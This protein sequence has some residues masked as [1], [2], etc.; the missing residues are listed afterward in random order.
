MKVSYGIDPSIIKEN[1][2][3]RKYIKNGITYSILNYD[4]LLIGDDVDTMNYRS[5]VVYN[6]NGNCNDYVLSFSPPKS[7]RLNVFLEK[8]KD[9]NILINEIVEGS[10]INLWYDENNYCWE[11]STKT[12]IGGNNFVVDTKLSFRDMF[13]DAMETDRNCSLDDIKF[14]KNFN[15]DYNYSFVL[16]HPKNHFVLTAVKPQLYLIAVYESKCINQISSISQEIYEK[17]FLL[18]DKMIKF[19][20]IY[21]KH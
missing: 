20:Q 15:K 18:Q 7:I 10:M 5:V 12:V 17:W 14:L 16:Q 13:M 11:I 21:K 19:P 6:G 8:Y 3:R 1:I 2:I 4:K 9:E